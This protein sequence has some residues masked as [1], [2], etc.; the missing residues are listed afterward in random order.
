MDPCV[1]K[2]WY[3]P[4]PAWLVWGAAVAVAVLFACERWRWFPEHYQKGWPVLAAVAVVAAFLVLIPAWLLAAIVFPR[5]VQFGLQTVLVFVTVCA[6]VCSWLAVRIKEARRQANLVAAITEQQFGEVWYDWL[7]DDNG[8]FQC[9]PVQPEPE[10]LKELL[11]VDF[12]HNVEGARLSGY[13]WRD[14]DLRLLAGLTRMNYL[15]LTTEQVTDGGLRHLEGLTSLR[16]L[17]LVCPRVTDNGVKR[18]QC[19]LP[20]CK[21]R[22]GN[23][24]R[25]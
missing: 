12:F 1:A 13:R 14:A 20:D 3:H 19:A 16:G 2:R 24:R 10:P 7:Y 21:I 22:I 8:N 23:E 5:R 25:E 18:L 17:H 11:G 4:S 6:V 15:G 9:N